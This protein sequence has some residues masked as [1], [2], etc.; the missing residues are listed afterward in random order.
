[1]RV[2]KLSKN[3]EDMHTRDEV[4]HYFRKTL[5]EQLGRFGLTQHK[6]RMERV[7]RGTLL[8]FTYQKELMFVARAADSIATERGWSFVPLKLS[9]LKPVSGSLEEFERL[10]WKR[11]L[12]KKH[13]VR[14]QAWP[15]LSP[16]IESFALAY[17]SSP[18]DPDRA[19]ELHQ[20]MDDLYY[21][22]GKAIGYWGKRYHRAL[23]THG[24]LAT[25]KRMLR[26]KSNT[27]I[28]QG[29]ATL[30]EF[31]RADQLSVEAIVQRPRF[32]SLFTPTE[33]AEARRRLDQPL[34]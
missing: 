33:I 10:L 9:T 18:N 4:V 17:L 15:E 5:P 13:L 16:N 12:T 31:G 23:R 30:K 8:L 32:R 2:I 7:E 24:G 19:L 25:A 34:A 6:S 28:D 1:M 21:S 11:N 20:A 14:T 29:L 3:D 26:P 22:A 27:A